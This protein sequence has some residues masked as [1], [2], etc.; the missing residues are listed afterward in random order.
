MLAQQ[1]PTF[2]SA[3][4]L[5]LVDVAVTDRHGD[6][7]DLEPS[8]FSLTI[9]KRRIAVEAFYHVV[10]NTVVPVPSGDGTN[11]AGVAYT[12]VRTFILF[13]DTNI[14]LAALD[15][16]K[17]AAKAF[18]QRELGNG[19]Y[20]G[21]IVGGRLVQGR[22]VT[23][24]EAAIAAVGSV[25]PDPDALARMTGPAS[26]APTADGTGRARADAAQDEM[27]AALS[28]ADE[29][30]GDGGAGWEQNKSLT[31]LLATVKGMQSLPGRKVI[32]LLSNGFPLSGMMPGDKSGTGHVTMATIVEAASA[33]GVR[34]YTVD[35]RGL[36]QGFTTSTELFADAPRPLGTSVHGDELGVPGKKNPRVAADDVLASLA[37]DTGGLWLHNE[38]DLSRTFD[39]ISRDNR[40]YYV[41]GYD[42]SGADRPDQITIHVKRSGVAVR[43]RINVTAR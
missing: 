27:N 5:A 41:L 25:R 4:T 35:P 37:L 7:V 19:D 15:R 12:P 24:R 39:R 26:R 42:A 31:K 21:I 40:S 2:R 13:F 28:R 8:D 43:A 36:D 18:L 3:K 11:R 30:I 23:T 1:A 32:V 38:N 10:D 6:A 22:L 34:I 9:D 14:G 17:T 20:A 33:A 29:A 16:A